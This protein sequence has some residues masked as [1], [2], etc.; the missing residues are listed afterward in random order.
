MSELDIIPPKR[1]EKGSLHCT[2]NKTSSMF[3]KG[4]INAKHLK[5]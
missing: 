2:V 4:A 5:P 3:N 1:H